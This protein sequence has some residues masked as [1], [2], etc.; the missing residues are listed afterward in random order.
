[1]KKTQVFEAKDGATFSTAEE[2]K[3]HEEKMFLGELCELSMLNVME[4]IDRTN[5]DLADAFERI[6]NII[7]AKRRE[8]GELKRSKPAKT[9]TDAVANIKKN[10]KAIS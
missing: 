1:M 3:K 9:T 2:C 7:A 5:V 8:N 4:A 6:G 10:M